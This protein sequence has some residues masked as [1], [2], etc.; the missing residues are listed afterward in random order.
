MTPGTISV[1]IKPWLHFPKGIFFPFFFFVYICDAR[2]CIARRIGLS[3]SAMSDRVPLDVKLRGGGEGFIDRIVARKICIRARCGRTV[4]NALTFVHARV[5]VCA[6][7][8]NA[9]SI[10][11]TQSYGRLNA[12][13]VPRADNYLRHSSRLARFR[14]P[15]PA[16]DLRRSQST[17]SFCPSHHLR[18]AFT[19]R[20]AFRLFARFRCGSFAAL[21]SFPERDT[22]NRSPIVAVYLTG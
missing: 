19:C 6:L 7:T 11:N 12:G 15:Q 20:F 5:R 16:Q 4:A 10:I 2:I 14:K 9:P 3:R 8:S 21:T 17:K 22:T 18:V 13:S 1:A